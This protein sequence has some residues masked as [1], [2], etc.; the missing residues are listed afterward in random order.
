MVN[1]LNLTG[2]QL[3]D[4]NNINSGLLPETF[5]GITAFFSCNIVAVFLIVF[6]IIIALIIVALFGIIINLLKKL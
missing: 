4:P 6:S 2:V 1:Q 5:H 3:V